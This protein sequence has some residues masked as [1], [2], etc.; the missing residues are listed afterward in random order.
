MKNKLSSI[1]F[2]IR[3]LQLGGAE[4]VVSE[5]SNY[6]AETYQ[7]KIVTF[8]CS[9]NEYILNH[10]VNR[11]NLNF[12]KTKKSFFSNMMKLKKCCCEIHSDLYISFDMLANFYS[13]MAL[14][15]TSYRLGISERNSPHNVRLKWYSRLLRRI[16]Y[17]KADFFVFQTSGAK[18]YYSKTIQKRA[19]V[20]PNPIKRNLPSKLYNK[21]FKSIVAIGRLTYQKNYPLMLNAFSIVHEKKPDIILKIYG[22]GSELDALQKK[23][24]ELKIAESVIFMGN[25]IKVHSEII[26]DDIF[27]LSSRF[28]GIPNALLE[29]MGMG[30]PVI[31]TDCPCGGPKMLIKDGFN[32]FL[33]SCDNV[34][35]LAETML[36][37]IN[38]ADLANKVGNNARAVNETYSIENISKLWCDMFTCEIGK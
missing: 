35:Q 1:T 33:V 11:I 22:V 26:N 5:I 16:L 17:K 15:F 29:A 4:R 36:K 32:G 10:N 28:E 30:F 3:S 27:V 13:I 14:R 38:N 8:D 21:E 12:G 25:S 6:L 2:I 31:S 24:D 9:D 18:L 20:I 19:Y 37:V 23:C 34:D 7:I